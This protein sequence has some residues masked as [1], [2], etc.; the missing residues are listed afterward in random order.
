MNDI[1]NR[2]TSMRAKPPY[3]FF[4]LLMT[5]LIGCTK[6]VPEVSALEAVD[7]FYKVYLTAADS[8]DGGS[9]G[10]KHSTALQQEMD[11]NRQI[12]KEY[13]TFIC[14]WDGEGDPYLYAILEVG[15]DISYETS[16]IE[17]AEISPNLIQVKL[18]A[19]PASYPEEVSVITYKMI[20]EENAWVADDIFYGDEMMSVRR[21]IKEENAGYIANPDEGSIADL[22]RSAAH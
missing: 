5:G 10:F 18:K 14:G 21:S 13:A 6:S 4:V 19:R 20:R 7:N 2:F 11:K 1:L 3:L 17:L 8:S 15:D 9:R 12:C 16:D 22:K